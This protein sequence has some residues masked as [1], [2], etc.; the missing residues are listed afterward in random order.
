MH[1]DIEIIHTMLI[2]KLL[3]D[4]QRILLF[5]HIHLDRQEGIALRRLDLVKRFD[6]F[7]VQVARS[8]NDC[9]SG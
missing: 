5:R 6:T 9:R 1:K 8:C 3:D 4:V 7:V 2:L